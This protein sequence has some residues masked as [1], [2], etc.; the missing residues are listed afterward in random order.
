MRR[1]TEALHWSGTK[2]KSLDCNILQMKFAQDSSTRY[3]Q[4]LDYKT[5]HFGLFLGP[6]PSIETEMVDTYQLA[7]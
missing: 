4:N 7:W 1:K 5:T 3:L 6:P 2:T